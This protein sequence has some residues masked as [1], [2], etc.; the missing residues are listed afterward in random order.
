LMV[1]VVS[2]PDSRQTGVATFDQG[3]KNGYA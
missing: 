3:G 2:P 1:T